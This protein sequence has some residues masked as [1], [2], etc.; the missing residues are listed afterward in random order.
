[1]RT[2]KYNGTNL[3]NI[4]DISVRGKTSLNS[5]RCAYLKDIFTHR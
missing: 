1:M 5:S 3:W 4:L 2:F